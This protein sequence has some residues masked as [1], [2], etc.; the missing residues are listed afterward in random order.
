MAKLNKKEA[1]ASNKLS[2]QLADVL[3]NVLA[4]KSSGAEAT[5]Q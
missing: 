5:E 2:G 3:S 1:K 4:V